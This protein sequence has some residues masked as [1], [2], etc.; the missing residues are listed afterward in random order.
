LGL[1]YEFYITKSADTYI[2]DAAGNH[3]IDWK[4]D[5]R[6]LFSVG[7]N[8]NLGDNNRLGLETERS[9][10]GRYNTESMINANLRYSC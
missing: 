1:N 5:G 7:D 9:A 6:M 8:V 3:Q 10:F 4:K 2:M